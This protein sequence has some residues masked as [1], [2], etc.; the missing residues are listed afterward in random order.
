MTTKAVR[1][2]QPLL[3]V[4]P[5]S[6][7]LVV[8]DDPAEVLIRQGGVVC[9]V[10]GSNDKAALANPVPLGVDSGAAG[11][12]VR[13]EL[14]IYLEAGR[15]YDAA[16][17]VG[18]GDEAVVTV[19]PLPDISPD[20]AD[21]GD[22]GGGDPS[23]LFV[24]A[25][26]SGTGTELDPYTGWE[27]VLASPA[28]G[29]H[30]HFGGYF[31]TDQPLDFD[32]SQNIKLTGG[33]GYLAESTYTGGT[34]GTVG[35]RSSKITFTSGNPASWV[36]ARYSWGFRVS[37]LTLVNASTTFAG[38]LVD[39]GG[40]DPD[41]T[42][43]AR[44]ENVT[45]DNTTT[46]GLSVA[47][48]GLDNVVEVSFRQCAFSGGQYN[49]TVP[50]GPWSNAVRFEQCRFIHAT[51]APIKNPL[52]QWTFD[53]CIVEPM[54]GSSDLA[55]FIYADQPVIRLD[56][57]SCYMWDAGTGAPV[58]RLGGNNYGVTI[59][60]NYLSSITAAQPVFYDGNYDGFQFTG[61]TVDGSGQAGGQL[62]D[63]G[64]TITNGLIAGNTVDV[65]SPSVFDNS[66]DY[67][68]NGNITKSL[69][70]DANGV[71]LQPSAFGVTITDS[72]TAGQVLTA[73]SSTTA[74]WQ[75]PVGPQA[76][77]PPII[78]TA[79]AGDTTAVANWTAPASDGGSAITGYVVDTYSSSGTLL[80]TDTIGVVLTFTKTGLTDG[81]GV[82]F[83]V[84]AINTNGTGA[85]SAFSNTVT[86]TL[87][88]FDPTNLSGMQLYVKPSGSIWQDSAETTL[89]TA[90][91]APV[92][93]WDDSSAGAH[94]LLQAV[95]GSRP[96]LKL[97]ILNGLRGVRFLGKYLQATFALVQPYTLFLV[98]KAAGGG[99]GNQYFADGVTINTIALST[100]DGTTARVYAGAILDLTGCNLTAYNIIILKANGA[101]SRLIVGSAN[102]AGNI[103]AGNP[104]GITLGV[105]GD[106]STGQL[107]GD[108]VFGGVYDSALSDANI[109]A[110]GDFL[111][112]QTA[113]PFTH[114]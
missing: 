15:G 99:V 61:N 107:Q 95:S 80:S 25:F 96:I 68:D 52:A 76:P 114:V 21:V 67:V 43:G 105:G 81:V 18:T 40:T 87:P 101:S 113:L 62:F 97:S 85:Q 50:T 22:A 20:V 35:V 51:K 10:F 13:G 77:G 72:P 19:V 48:L 78:G 31:A 90:D 8:V 83:K 24:A 45:I 2:T 75:T 4:V 58:F 12:S 41:I 29:T 14:L 33:D 106:L 3:G 36:S 37:G 98:A 70:V 27:S 34:M 100:P 59:E 11:V 38:L 109:N 102:I 6:V 110:L 82:K 71:Q 103:G 69:V 56:V 23:T 60:G 28:P 86:P 1:Y 44:F 92:G 39:L 26:G 94:D 49:V 65:S 42:V 91:T 64:V 111:A 74:T 30:F 89:A 55:T 112:A 63:G 7:A 32:L 88:P 108:V 54:S 46:N 93:A 73:T 84:A 47:C 104:G 5:G 57:R 17:T 66:A 79:T 53:S 9:T 16:I